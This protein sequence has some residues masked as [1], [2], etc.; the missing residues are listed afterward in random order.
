M[1]G[2]TMMDIGLFAYWWSGVA[3]TFSVRPVSETGIDRTIRDRLRLVCGIAVPCSS[4]NLEASS[5]CPCAD[6]AK[7]KSAIV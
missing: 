6:L 5:E 1:I 7:A 2:H 4:G 3:G